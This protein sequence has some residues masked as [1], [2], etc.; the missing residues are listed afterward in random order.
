MCGA[1]TAEKAKGSGVIGF[2]VLPVL[3]PSNQLP[4]TRPVVPM[5][6][7]IGPEVVVSMSSMST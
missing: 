2:A 3:M 7:R 6:S 1:G 4:A 5:L